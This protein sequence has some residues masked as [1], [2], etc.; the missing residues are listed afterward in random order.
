MRKPR[1]LVPL[2]GAILSTAA[3]PQSPV[4]A[5]RHT[6][7]QI[8]HNGHYF[9]TDGGKPFYWQGDTEWELLRLF[10]VEDAKSLSSERRKQGFNVVQVM[11]TG[12]FPEWN[13][14]RG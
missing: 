14:N 2:L 11:A 13:I 3:W 10:S 6:V 8:S 7:L 12:V 1:V 5:G 4:A 9:V